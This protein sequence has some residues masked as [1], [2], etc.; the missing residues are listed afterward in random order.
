[1]IEIEKPEITIVEVSED[2]KYGKIVIEPLERGYAQPL[3]IHYVV[4]Y[5]P[6]Y[7]EQQLQIFK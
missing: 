3:E 7:P 6:H 1:M 2:E 5:Y 4:S